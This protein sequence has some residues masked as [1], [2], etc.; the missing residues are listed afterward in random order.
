MF[1]PESNRSSSDGR[2]QPPG[3]DPR[4]SPQL[5]Q[6]QGILQ[7]VASDK[8][9]QDNQSWG[10]V[11]PGHP[12]GSL[13]EHVAQL[14][15]SLNYLVSKFPELPRILTEEGLLKIKILILVHDSMKPEAKR[16]VPVEHQRN[17]ATLAANFLRQHGGA[18]DL[19]LMTKLHDEHHALYRQSQRGGVENGRLERI[20]H[21]IPSWDLFLTFQVCD[22]VG[23][24]RDLGSIQWL[25]SQLRERQVDFIVPADEMISTLSALVCPSP[26]NPD[27]EANK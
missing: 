8:R 10:E 3:G 13:R 22:K 7:R 15:R 23:P 6:L 5:V 1:G 20:L 12:E 19:I 25:V 26:H 17:H 2:G 4:Q 21:S 9:F 14:S 16:G 18:N 24:G 11:R 27:F